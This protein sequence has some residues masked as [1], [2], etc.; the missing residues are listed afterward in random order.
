MLRVLKKK[1]M[2]EFFKKIQDKIFAIV[3]TIISVICLYFY[4]AHKTVQDLPLEKIRR[5]IKQTQDNCKIANDELEKKIKDL[6]AQ[7]HGGDKV[8]TGIK[9]VLKGLETKSSTLELLF[10]EEKRSRT[11]NNDTIYKKLDKYS[12]KINQ[13]AK[14]I[15]YLKGKLK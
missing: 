15:A 4:S 12:D 3:P 13:N 14:D 11:G 7:I 2:N 5:E 10:N 8:E 9:S 1:T 6:E